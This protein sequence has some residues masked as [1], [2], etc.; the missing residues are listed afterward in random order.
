MPANNAIHISRFKASAKSL[1]KSV[2]A[3]DQDA[4][5]KIRPYFDKPRDFTL[6][7]AQLVIARTHQCNSWKQLI[8]K[9]DWLACSFCGK[10]Q[11]DVMKLIAGPEVYVC[12][13]CVELCNEI[14]RDE[15]AAGGS[16]PQM[17]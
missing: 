4:L 2:K 13:E 14:L 11:Y 12:D 9:D 7:Q 1:L 8:S 5:E 10:W 15:R 6:V 17:G 3:G 16:P